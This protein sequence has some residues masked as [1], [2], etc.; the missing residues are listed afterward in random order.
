MDIHITGFDVI[1]NILRSY[2]NVGDVQDGKKD[3]FL[4][5]EREVKILKTSLSGN[6]RISYTSPDTEVTTLKAGQTFTKY[7]VC[8]SS[9][10]YDA[11][12]YLG[13]M[14]K[15]CQ[16][17]MDMEV[18]LEKMEADLYDSSDSEQKREDILR[19]NKNK[20]EL[21]QFI[22]DSNNENFYYYLQALKDD[23]D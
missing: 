16:E 5:T 15:V 19:L 8:Y 1:D 22:K 9:I 17:Q 2:Q 4:N 13:W 12:A 20:Q 23:G 18:I 10:Y 21:Y 3:D 6:G 14:V 11:T 7:Y